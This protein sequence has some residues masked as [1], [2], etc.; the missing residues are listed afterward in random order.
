[1]FGELASHPDAL[2]TL[3]GEKQCNLFRH[4]IYL[5]VFHLG[6]SGTSGESTVQACWLR[7]SAATNFL[8]VPAEFSSGQ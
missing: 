6:A 5:I 7:H 4:G 2:R 3:T 1:L 8:L